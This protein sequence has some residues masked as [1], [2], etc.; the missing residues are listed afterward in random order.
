MGFSLNKIS[1]IGNLGKDA[2][3]RFTTNNSEITTFSV[4]TTYSYKKDNNYVNETTWH[5]VVLFGASDHQKGFLKKGS[6]IYL[7]GR[8]NKRNYE[9]KEGVKIYVTEIIADKYSLIPLDS[10]S[11]PEVKEPIDSGKE[12]DDLPF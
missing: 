4:A 5:D 6:K 11:K 8:L 10:E 7:E 9:N 12:D 3:H 2:E 1:I